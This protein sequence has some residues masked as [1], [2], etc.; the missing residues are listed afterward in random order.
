MA[1]GDL[2]AHCVRVRARST[3][4]SRSADMPNERRRG[5]GALKLAPT[6]CLSFLTEGLIEIAYK[7]KYPRCL[8]RTDPASR[9]YVVATGYTPKD[10]TYIFGGS[11]WLV[12]SQRSGETHTRQVFPSMRLALSGRSRCLRLS[13]PSPD[14]QGRDSFRVR[15]WFSCNSLRN[16]GQR[17]TQ[18]SIP[19][20]HRRAIWKRGR[21]LTQVRP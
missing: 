10:N 12:G 20:S 19:L 11:P 18:C 14:V 1:C 21:G 8:R 15:S 5:A 7:L 6:D 3:H 16:G 4:D 9:A 13:D 2:R 17:A